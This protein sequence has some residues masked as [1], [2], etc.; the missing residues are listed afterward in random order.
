[1]AR[2]TPSRSRRCWPTWRAARPRWRSDR[3]WPRSLRRS[4]RMCAPAI[5]GARP[6]VEAA[7]EYARVHGPVLHPFEAWLLRRGLQTYGLRM[8]AHNRN[9]LD[10]ARFLES[11][12]AVE[13]VYFP[14]LASHPQHELARQ[15]M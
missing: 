9:A 14:G 2:Q 6:L 5:I 4:F 1:M 3:A 11:H 7:W 8:A 12:S 15:Q 10:V 13:R